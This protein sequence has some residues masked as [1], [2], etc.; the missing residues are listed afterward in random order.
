MFLELVLWTIRGAVALL[1]S[2]LLLTLGN[3]KRFRARTATPSKRKVVFLHPDLGIGGAERL[4]VD[5]AVG[6]QSGPYFNKVTIY[7]NHHDPKR[8]FSET[9]DGTLD[10]RTTI[11]WLP[12][13]IAGKGHVF[14]ATMRMMLAAVR[15]A[16]TETDAD[17]FFVDQVAAAMPVLRL[18][19]PTPVFFYCHFPDQ[20]C[21]PSQ[22]GDQAK[23]NRSLFRV[24]YRAVFNRF[25]AWATGCASR[26]VTNSRFTLDM[27]MSTF[28]GLILN[29]EKDVLYPAINVDSLLA[30]ISPEEEERY[31]ELVRLTRTRMCI[32]SINRFERKKNLPLALRAFAELRGRVNS[33]DREKLHLIVAGGFDPRLTENVDHHLELVSLAH[34][35]LNLPRDTVTFLRSFT[36]TEKQI[37]LRGATVVVYTPTGEHFGIVPIEAMA[38]S[39]PV[40]A[41]NSGGP[42]ESVTT[43]GRYGL[44]CAAEPSA[45]CE[46][47]LRIVSNPK[48]RETMGKAA[49][50]RCMAK[51]SLT[52]FAAQLNKCLEEL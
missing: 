41:V 48:L 46:G 37:L 20:L 13:S 36:N 6:I 30:E 19:T 3:R 45:F 40:V 23:R 51:F 22:M 2:I 25:E 47:L 16:L 5:A 9:T 14:F 44:L 24:L 26:I 10:V 21:D 38:F 27:A 39:K 34:D 29:P 4:I 31:S 52:A 8:A 43:D 17:V 11:G 18:L 15:L 50:E 1:S 7:T 35:E 12:R 32:V 33:E 28:P 49:H 42:T